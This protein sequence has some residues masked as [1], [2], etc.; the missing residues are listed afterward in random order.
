M[1][2]LRYLPTVT[3]KVKSQV[4][5]PL[6]FRRKMFYDQHSF[7]KQG[8]S[9]VGGDIVVKEVLALALLSCLP[10]SLYQLYAKRQE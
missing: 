1:R 9:A 5:P 7:L 3:K 10:H 2:F 6:S 8:G 4:H